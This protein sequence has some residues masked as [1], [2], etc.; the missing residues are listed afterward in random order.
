[1]LVAAWAMKKCRHFILGCDSFLLA[2]DHKPLLSLLGQKDL[3]DI[4][5]P[6]LQ[7]LKKKTMRYAFDIIHVPGRLNKGADA[8][9]RMPVG[10]A[11]SFLLTIRMKPS[12]SEEKESYQVEENIK[13]IAMSSLYGIYQRGNPKLIECH[14]T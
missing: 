2:V 14:Q 1:M 3:E 13:G 10:G 5:N 6:R 9:S 8:T 12:E 4:E 11:Q 7:N